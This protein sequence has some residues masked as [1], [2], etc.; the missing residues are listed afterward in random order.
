MMT[1]GHVV[2]ELTGA[3]ERGQGVPAVGVFHPT[4]F[5]QTGLRIRDS[6][7]LGDDIGLI[8]VDFVIPCPRGLGLSALVQDPFTSNLGTLVRSPGFAYGD[9]RVGDA[10]YISCNAHFKETV[11]ADIGRYHPSS[12]NERRPVRVF[13]KCRSARPEG[14][15][16]RHCYTQTVELWA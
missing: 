12:R 8:E 7:T 4:N 2:E 16:A 5:K 1:A 14:I 13:L 9:H 3:L 11:V 6:E 15:L 10:R